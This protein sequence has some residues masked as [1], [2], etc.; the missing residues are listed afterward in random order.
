MKPTKFM[1][2]EM[3]LEF[4]ENVSDEERAQILRNVAGSMEHEISNRGI[5]PDGSDNCTKKMTVLS[6]TLGKAVEYD[7]SKITAKLTETDIEKCD[8]GFL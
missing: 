6:R 7:L 3:V 4:D 5:L 2:L 8:P 1:H